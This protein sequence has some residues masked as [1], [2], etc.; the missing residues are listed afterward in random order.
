MSQ[1]EAHEV[2]SVD[3]P[4]QPAETDA[5][6]RQ[7]DLARA[8]VGV[9]VRRRRDDSSRNTRTKYWVF[10]I[11]NPRLSDEAFVA[12]WTTLMAAD[13]SYVSFQREVSESGTE[14]IQ[15]YVAFKRRLR[16]REAS[17]QPGFERASLRTREGTPDQ[18][19]DYTRKEET[20]MQGILFIIINGHTYYP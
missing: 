20:R 17:R 2:I 1:H 3:S 8:A 11:N 16:M 7:L 19:R 14:H 6:R 12:T 10:T 18:A 5:D 9:G 13:I 4:A 15:G